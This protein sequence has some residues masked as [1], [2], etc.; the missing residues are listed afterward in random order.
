MH[1]FEKITGTVSVIKKNT[2][3]LQVLLL[4]KN[5]AVLQAL[6]GKNTAALQ[7]LHGKNTATELQA[8]FLK[9]TQPLRLM[10]IKAH[11]CNRHRAQSSGKLK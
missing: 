11:T 8:S 5:T 3:A 7:A 1:Y 10:R 9:K 6:H 4:G 2:A